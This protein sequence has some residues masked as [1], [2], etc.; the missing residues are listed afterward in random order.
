V[1]LTDVPNAASDRMLR[2]AGFVPLGETAGPR[3]PLRTYLRERP[4]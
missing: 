3:Y 2:R 4:G 1:V